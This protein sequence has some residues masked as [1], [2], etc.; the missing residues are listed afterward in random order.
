M[1]KT[2]EIFIGVR[3]EVCFEYFL[4]GFHLRRCIMCIAV[5]QKSAVDTEATNPSLKE[6]ETQ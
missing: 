2:L 3:L 1:F 5:F 6:A 4:V